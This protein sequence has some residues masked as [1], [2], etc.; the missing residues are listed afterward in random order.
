MHRAHQRGGS[1]G[2]GQH[3][4]EAVARREGLHAEG[5]PVAKLEACQ[6]EG[7]ARVHHAVVLALPP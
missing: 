7:R 1:V 3:I 6:I 2:G 4:H 5:G